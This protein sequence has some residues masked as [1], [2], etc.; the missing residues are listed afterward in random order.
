M[1][2]VFGKVLLR[3]KIFEILAKKIFEIN[4]RTIK[5]KPKLN[6]KCQLSGYGLKFPSGQAYTSRNRCGHGDMTSKTVPRLY[7][8]SPLWFD[9]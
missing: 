8:T 4:I 9:C 2:T 7:R 3:K 6:Y 5:S 1:P